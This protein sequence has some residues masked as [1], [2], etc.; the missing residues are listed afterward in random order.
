MARATVNRALQGLAEAG[1]LDRRRKAGTRV[2]ALPVRKATF[3]IPVLRQE[4]EGAGRTYAHRLLSQA[5]ALPPAEVAAA[6]GTTGRLVH[7][8]AL[9][10][11][12]G[13][14]LAHEDRWINPAAVPAIRQAD[15]TRVSAN[16]WLVREAAFTHGDYAV[17]AQNAGALAGPLACDPGAAVLCVTRGTW[18]GEIAVTRVVLTFAPGHAIRAAL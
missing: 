4:V 7:V 10:L 8:T 13:A 18:A 12:D 16:E 11:A 3:S 14:P 5:D 6:M 17:T 2:A 1:W 9:H 15:L